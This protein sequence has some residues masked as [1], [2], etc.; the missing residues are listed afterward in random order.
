MGISSNSLRVGRIY[1]LSRLNCFTASDK[2][3]I[4]SFGV[5]LGLIIYDGSPLAEKP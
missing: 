2:T 5:G 3:L 4:F 1:I